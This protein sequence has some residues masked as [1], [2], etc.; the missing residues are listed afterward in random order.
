VPDRTDPSRAGRPPA[1]YATSSE[2]A[3]RGCRRP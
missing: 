3:R 1:F 2:P